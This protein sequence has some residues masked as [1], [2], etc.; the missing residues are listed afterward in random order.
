MNLWLYQSI[1]IIFGYV[2]S[3]YDYLSLKKTALRLILIMAFFESLRLFG[4]PL[5][6]N[7]S[8]IR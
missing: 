8:N 4:Y 2:M 5:C 1:F 6:Y 7:I 3:I